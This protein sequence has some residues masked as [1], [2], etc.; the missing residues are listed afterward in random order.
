MTDIRDL[1]IDM[2]PVAPCPNGLPNGSCIAS[3]EGK[4]IL[5]PSLTLDH[6]LYI[7]NVIC[8]LLSI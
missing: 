4:V 3:Y 2:I 7:S 8:N 1:L 6:V 5:S